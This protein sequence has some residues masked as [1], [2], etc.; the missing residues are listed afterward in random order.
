MI[1]YGVLGLLQAFSVLLAVIVVTIGT[2]RASVKVKLDNQSIP[3]LSITLTKSPWRKNYVVY[4]DQ[5]S[6]AAP[7]RKLVNILFWAIFNLFCSFQ[8]FFCEYLLSLLEYKRPVAPFLK[9]HSQHLQFGN[10]TLSGTTQIQLT[11]SQHYYLLY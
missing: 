3:S 2:L 1:V 7:T 5:L 8:M 9:V 4:F 10:I 6:G 11:M